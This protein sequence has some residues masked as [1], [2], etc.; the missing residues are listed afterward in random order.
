MARRDTLAGLPASDRKRL[1]AVAVDLGHGRG[2]PLSVLIQGWADHVDRLVS[3]RK[4]DPDDRG[5]W[6]ADDLVATLYLRDFVKKGERDLP[7]DLTAAVRQA[8]GPIDAAFTE[9][10]TQDSEGLLRRWVGDD[11]LGEGWWWGRVPLAGPVLDDLLELR[12]RLR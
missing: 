5:R 11:E 6:T 2:R 8:I 7:E 12:E 3:E 1:A 9:F 4:L 10:T